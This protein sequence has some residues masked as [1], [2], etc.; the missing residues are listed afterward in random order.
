[1]TAEVEMDNVIL[2]H[3]II[4]NM[5]ATGYPDGKFP[6]ERRCPVCNSDNC[7]SLFKDSS[8][9]IVGCDECVT[10]IYIDEWED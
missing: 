6:K 7:W 3:P 10:S 9:D 4:R 5:E 1:M 2:D 8:G